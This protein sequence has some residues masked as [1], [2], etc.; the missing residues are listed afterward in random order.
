MRHA[1]FL[2]A[3]LCAAAQEPA[4][5]LSLGAIGGRTEFHI[6]EPIPITLDFEVKGPQN[7]QIATD[8]RLRHLRPQGLDEFS[9]TPADGW[10]D[11]LGDLQWTMDA[12][13]PS[14]GS[15]GSARLDALHPV[16]IERDLNEFIVFHKPGRYVVHAISARVFGA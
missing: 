12:M 15:W 16:H 3:A 5:H 14:N 7:F 13:G 6:G 1:L 10:V 4:V 11:P 8:I 2:L 9:A